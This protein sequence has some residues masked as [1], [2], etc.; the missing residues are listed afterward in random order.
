MIP[1]VTTPAHTHDQIIEPAKPEPVVATVLG[2][3]IAVYN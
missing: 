2:T 3:V 1:A